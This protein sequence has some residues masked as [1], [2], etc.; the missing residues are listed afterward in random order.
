MTE[1]TIKLSKAVTEELARLKIHP[2]QS[3]EEIIK[4]LL[5]KTKVE[6]NEGT[7]NPSDAHN[8]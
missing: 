8:I 6:L 7:D 1:T 4:Q 5:S 2:R 3:Y